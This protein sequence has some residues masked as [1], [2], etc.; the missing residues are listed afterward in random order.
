MGLFSRLLGSLNG[1]SNEDAQTLHTSITRALTG[2]VYYDSTIGALARALG[3]DQAKQRTNKIVTAL[4]Q[5]LIKN[6]TVTGKETLSD[7][8]G[9]KVQRL[10][11]SNLLLEDLQLCVNYFFDSAIKDA[12]DLHASKTIPNLLIL[13]YSEFDKLA[14]TID[15]G[16]AAAKEDP[17]VDNVLTQE[18]VNAAINRLNKYKA[19][20]C[21]VDTG[22]GKIA[23]STSSL[24]LIEETRKL[25]TI[26]EILKDEGSDI[27]CI[28]ET[29]PALISSSNQQLAAEAF[30]ACIQR[31]DRLAISSLLNCIGT[32][33]PAWQ[34]DA[35]PVRGIAERLL[36][37]GLSPNTEYNNEPLIY[38]AIDGNGSSSEY[39]TELLIRYRADLNV[40]NSDGYS[41][42]GAHL[43]SHNASLYHFE[44]YIKHGA[45]LNDKDLSDFKV[46]EAIFLGGLYDIAKTIPQD[47]LKTFVKKGDEKTGLTLLHLAAGGIQ[48][49]A[50]QKL[51]ASFKEKYLDNDGY[52]SVIKLLLDCGADPLQK[53]NSGYDA[54]NIALKYGHNEVY[55]ILDERSSGSLAYSSRSIDEPLGGMGSALFNACLSGDAAEVKFLLEAGANPNARSFVNYSENDLFKPGIPQEVGARLFQDSISRHMSP[56]FFHHME[57]GITNLYYPAMNGNADIVHMLLEAGADPN[58]ICYN[59]LFPLYVAAENGNLAVVK[60]LISYG[61]EIN[62][63]TPKGCTS[64]L[65]A[66]EEGETDTIRYLLDNGADPYIRNKAGQN[67]IDAAIAMGQMQTAQMMMNYY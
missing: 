38:A 11:E 19:I 13:A 63:T 32:D 52:P 45:R 44:P 40:T 64:I 60:E 66:A 62:K 41:P 28:S 22:I 2:V 59:G 58:A 8:I 31:E 10:H 5:A 47:K 20:S 39:Y 54:A 65:N 51:Q 21:Y 67:A 30:S 12:K 57:Y 56:D 25:Q 9:I 34:Y 1:K 29:I 18:R 61:A 7:L 4:I 26:I 3:D 50:S 42:L 6:K 36:S 14:K 23:T 55:N 35:N 17:G 49:G 48:I 16:N 46:Y 27:S 24:A 37:S 33:S 53:T 43:R 15:I